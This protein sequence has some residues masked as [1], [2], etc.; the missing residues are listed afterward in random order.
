MLRLLLFFTIALSMA[1]AVL[2]YLTKEKAADLTSTL[3][4]ANQNVSVL[5]N[6]NSKLKEEKKTV[7]AKVEELD[8][9]VQSQKAEADKLRNE[10]TAKQSEIAKAQA[11]LAQAKEK[12]M[13]LE[14]QLEERPPAAP[15]SAP[16]PAAEQRLAEL[17]LELEKAKQAASE[18]QKEA[19]LK[20]KQA[21]AKASLA[22]VKRKAEAAKIAEKKVPTEGQVVEY[23]A[24]WNF[25]VVNL[26]DKQG[27][28][29]ESKLQVS[30]GGKVLAHLDITEVRPKF[31][32]A[33]IVYAQGVPKSAKLKLGDT[34]QFVPR[35]EPDL[36]SD[37][38]SLNPSSS[39]SRS[40]LDPLP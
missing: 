32:T 26:G 22:A 28:T 6:D 17:R 3:T 20:V 30:R 36:T 12:A 7:E 4:A 5:K 40:S 11:D 25:V 13:T 27:V 21:E 29:P 35:E 15:A 9:G 39:A 8:K 31:A 19:E 24:D 14:K 18:I 1:S 2:A 23:N 10:T 38:L 33:G 37:P 16:D 34:V